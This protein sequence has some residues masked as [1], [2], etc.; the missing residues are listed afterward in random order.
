[1]TAT[2]TTKTQARKPVLV[3]PIAMRL[4]ATE[5]QRV[6]DL[7]RS[8]RA[9][10]WSKPTDCPGWDVR[11]MACHMLGMAEMAASIREQTRQVKTAEKNNGAFIDALT[12]LQVDERATMTPEQIVSRLAQVAPKAARGRRWAPGLIRRRTMPQRQLVDGQEESW[13]IG[14]L[15]DVILTR[16]P[17]M[18]RIDISRATGAAHALT[19]GHDG[20][21]VDDLV[22]EWARRGTGPP[23]R[24]ATRSR[25]HRLRPRDFASQVD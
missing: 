10:D 7:L 12:A 14:Y 17:W 9:E 24:P 20:V 18:H 16:D 2:A 8:L 6:V 19:A 22:T 3:R 25:R 4:A 15:I 5:Y 1:M 11:A 13:T 21:I 23:R